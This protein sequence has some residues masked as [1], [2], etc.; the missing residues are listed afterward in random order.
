MI[1]SPFFTFKTKEL[2]FEICFCGFYCQ[3]TAGGQLRERNQPLAVVLRNDE[4]GQ[5]EQAVRGSQ[6][7]KT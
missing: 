5:W 4:H 6:C 3:V 2:L 7:D 1:H